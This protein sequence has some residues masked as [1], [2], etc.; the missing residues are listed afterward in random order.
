METNITLEV[1]IM[2][3]AILKI[4]AVIWLVGSVLCS[5]TLLGEYSEMLDTFK[6]D[7]KTE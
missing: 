1:I 4:A 6:L 7:G 3:N 2:L 5:F